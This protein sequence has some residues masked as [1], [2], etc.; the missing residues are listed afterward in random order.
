MPLYNK[1]VRD[2]IPAMLDERGVRARTRVLRGGRLV[3]ALRAKLG[4]ELAEYDAAPTPDDALGELADVL[5]V[6][7]AL[8]AAH[9]WSPSQLDDRR[10]RKAGERGTFS[11]GIEL[12]GTD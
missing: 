10:A 11:A 2:G 7:Y 6:V 3:A 12:I 4:E 9:G 1:L 5:E 8:A